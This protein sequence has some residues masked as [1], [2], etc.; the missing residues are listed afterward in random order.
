MPG[1]RWL[2][3]DVEK[4]EVEEETGKI[5]VTVKATERKTVENKPVSRKDE[6]EVVFESAEDSPLGAGPGADDEPIYD[7]SD[8]GAVEYVEEVPMQKR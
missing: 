8:L 2:K 5:D 4:T 6:A 7:L 3:I 1:H